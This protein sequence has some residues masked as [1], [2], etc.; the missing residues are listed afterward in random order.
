MRRALLLST[1]LPWLA[2][3]QLA[4]PE[5][6]RAQS[7]PLGAVSAPADNAPA[8]LVADQ[9]FITPDRTLVA[10]GNVEAF[11]GDVRLTA[12]KITFDQTQGALQIEGP[13]RIDEGGDITI[14][15]DAAELDRDLRN[16]L[17][18]G[19]RMVFQQQLQLASL[20][21][22][23]VGGRYTQLYKTAVTS[24]HVCNDGRPPLWQIRAERIT[25]DQQER[26][27]YL[28]NAQLRVLDTPIFY[29]PGIRLPDPTLERANGFLIPSIRT[30]SNLGTGVKVPY[31]LT[32][33][34]HRDLTLSPYLSSRTR[35]L[36][37][38]Y[39][40]AFRRG[41]IEINGAY[42][43]DELYRGED[44][45]YVFAEGT[46]DLR[47]EFKLRFDL[48]TVSDD[49]YLVDY[50][51]QDLDRLRSEVVVSKVQRDSLFRA[52]AISYKT[53]RDS[54]NQDLIPSSIGNLYYEKRFFPT[55]IG[56]ELR[57]SLETHGHNRT[58]DIKGTLTD[59]GGRDV[60]RATF[61]VDW[62]R[63]WR[64]D[65]GLVAEW[66]LG[67]AAD[68]F[69]VYD[70]SVFANKTSRF[71]PRSA[72]T[73]RLP[74]TRRE[75]S[76]ATQY[77]EPILQIGWT[78]TGDTA[79]PNDESNFVEFDRGNLLELSRFPATDARE[80]GVTVVYGL[81]WARFSP[82]GWQASATIGQVFRDSDDGR[83]TKSSGLGGT[84]SDLLMAAQLKLNDDLAIT[85]R[86]LL[87]G[88]LNF[89]KAEVRGDWMTD[90]SR[91]TGTYMW[92]GTDPAEGRS[93]EVSEL[94][95]DG[96]YEVTPGWTASASLR[97]DI[98]DARA[99]RAG[100]GLVYSNECVKVDLSV[101]RRYTST[102]SVEPTTDFGF[103]IAL[104]GFSVDSG[105]K[106]Y[107]RSCKN[108]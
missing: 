83:F 16:G 97:Y 98:S 53:L 31:F 36:D 94:W 63:S 27:L 74:M 95:F 67:A 55:R 51:L 15:A 102:T 47:N 99:T 14:L 49:A 29:F 28:E 3:G 106:K 19:A 101:N 85:T 7:A 75:Q 100:L 13:I 56:G 103:T 107:R 25:H 58:S 38:R 65:S 91:L 72:L 93:E 89:S 37:M 23:R 48:K 71:S 24:C 60:G 43:R 11:Q 32:I 108:T 70:D 33:G 4:L 92:L 78:N 66:S 5:S 41:E 50:G 12:R 26:Q 44:R 9:L 22:T 61:D 84:S 76:G 86:G 30:T 35:T 18:V 57:L 1:V 82:S 52:S 21:M 34:P 40:Q 69:A 8:I 96:A 42:T 20:Q 68:A 46:F 90:R 62:Q 80:D 81:N 6:A 88:S 105:S 73:F 104:N 39:R 17:L 77:L 10:E 79:V 2:L 45:G 64:F 87:N 54:E 59:P